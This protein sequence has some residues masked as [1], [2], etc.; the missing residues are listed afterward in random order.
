[1]AE[2]PLSK[3]QKMAAKLLADPANYG[4]YDEIAKTV[5]VLP[6]TLLKWLKKEQFMA[7]VNSLSRELV[8]QDPFGVWEALVE[9]CKNGDIQAMKLYFELASKR[10]AVETS[11]EIVVTMSKEA[12]QYAK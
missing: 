5:E 3:K 2:K 7:E 8:H 12:E 9:K 10:S 6:S 1:M 4:N 11:Q